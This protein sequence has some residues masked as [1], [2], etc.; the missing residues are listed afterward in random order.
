MVART[1]SARSIGGRETGDRTGEQGRYEKS[2]HI[3]SIFCGRF[4]AQRDDI[5]GL[6][7]HNRILYLSPE[8]GSHGAQRNCGARLPASN[9]NIVRE[10]VRRALGS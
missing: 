4:A 5:G 9:G 2:S 10:V 1:A 6:I 7:P 3:S 8:T